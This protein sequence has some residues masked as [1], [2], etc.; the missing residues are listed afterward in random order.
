VQFRE[1]PSD[2]RLGVRIRVDSLAD[3][4]QRRRQSR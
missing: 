3:K 4:L 2:T 1:F